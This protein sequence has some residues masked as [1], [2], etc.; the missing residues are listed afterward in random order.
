MLAR[1]VVFSQRLVCACHAVVAGRVARLSAPDFIAG[2]LI[3]SSPLAHSKQRVSPVS[4][5]RQRQL[6]AHFVAVSHTG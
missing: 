4:Q 3:E 2:R 6:K 1:T 5:Y